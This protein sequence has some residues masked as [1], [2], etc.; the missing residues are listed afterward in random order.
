MSYYEDDFYYPSEFEMMMEEFKNT[1][2]N[3]VRDE[4]KEELDMLRKENEDLS[5]IKSQWDELQREY[6]FKISELER[7]KD[8]LKREVR[9]ERLSEIMDDFK[10]VLYKVSY[11]TTKLDKCD[12]CDDYRMINYITPLGREAKEECHCKKPVKVY[13]VKEAFLYSFMD[14]VN[15]FYPRY[16]IHHNSIGSK[17]ELFDFDDDDFGKCEKVIKT[18]EEFESI[19]STYNTFFLTPELAQLYIDKLMS[20]ENK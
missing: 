5:E 14:N 8:N 19:T 9:K 20:E 3:S 10:T 15:N 7:I 13:S 1:L 16:L 2:R 12:K 11:N 18:A 6:K 4:I 17:F